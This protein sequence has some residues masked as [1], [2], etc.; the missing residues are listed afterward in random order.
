MTL[1][2]PIRRRRLHELLAER[3]LA[4]IAEGDPAPGEVL[5]SEAELAARHNVGRPTVREAL[6][7]LESMGVIAISH[8]ERARVVEPSASRVLEGV[9]ASFVH[10]LTAAPENIAHLQEVRLLTE[11]AMVRR[12]IQRGA[13][14][15]ALEEALVQ[16]ERA[17]RTGKGFFGADMEFHVAIADGAGN[18]LF[19]IFLRAM[20]DWLSAFRTSTVRLSGFEE[21]ALEEHRAIFAAMQACDAE[22]AARAMRA[23]LL[24]SSKLYGVHQ[25]T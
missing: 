12:S 22:G 23:H 21:L 7:K 14:L 6:Q 8:G 20:L 1:A 10:F 3:L 17:V 15:T 5:P 13:S 18:P 9:S 25:R 4:R 24:R 19:P 11:E 2:D 16:Q